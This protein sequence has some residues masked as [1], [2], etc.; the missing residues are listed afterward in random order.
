MAK[1]K[2]SGNQSGKQAKQKQVVAP[3]IEMRTG[4]IIV[5][6]TSLALG[7]LS[8]WEAIPVKGVWGGI[9]YGLLFAVMLWGV[10]FVMMM[11][12]RFLRRK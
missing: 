3:W 6:I 1:T 10:F 4:F 11:F 12:N 2:K 5:G 8:A 9:G 7:A